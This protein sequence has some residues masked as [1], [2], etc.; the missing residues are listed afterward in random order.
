[1][2]TCGAIELQA[3]D[4]S[5][6]VAMQSKEEIRDHKKLLNAL[7]AMDEDPG[8]SYN[9]EAFFPSK[10]VSSG[11]ELEWAKSQ[12]GMCPA[13]TICAEYGIKWEPYHGIWGGLTPNE[14]QSIRTPRAYNKSTEK[15]AS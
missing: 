2:C 6:P 12:C 8:C 3:H 11:W 15:K 13:Q 7:D 1:M 9:P 10:G 4:Y 5:C 14:R